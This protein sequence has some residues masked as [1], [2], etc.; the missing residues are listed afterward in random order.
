VRPRGRARNS[1]EETAKTLKPK[2]FPTIAIDVND[3]FAWMRLIVALAWGGEP[4]KMDRALATLAAEGLGVLTELNKLPIAALDL[5]ALSRL[6]DLRMDELV[7]MPGAPTFYRSYFTDPARSFRELEQNVFVPAGHYLAV[8]DAPERDRVLEELERAFNRGGCFAGVQLMLIATIARHHPE[9]SASLNRA[10]AV[11]EAWP[12][13]G[14]RK[15]PSD[16][17]LWEVWTK[18]RRLA[19]LWAAYAVELLNAGNLGF[20]A[21]AAGLEA[22]HDPIRRRRI[23]SGAKWFR[24]FAVSFSSKRNGDPLIPPGE[25]L[26]IIADVEELEPDLPPLPPDDLAAAKAYQAP[27]R[28][29]PP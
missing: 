20:T 1:E 21:D 5:P 3:R 27:N 24:S 7:R 6:L 19:P 28:K 15:I 29:F 22:V 8:A 4:R 12:A 11:M 23:L 25:A 17:T 13:R 14:A 9:M 10:I 18:W 26:R 2:T 16:R